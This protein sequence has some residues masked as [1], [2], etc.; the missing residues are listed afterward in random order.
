MSVEDPYP[1][2]SPGEHQEVPEYDEKLGDDDDED[3]EDDED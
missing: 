1:R 3:D 2:P